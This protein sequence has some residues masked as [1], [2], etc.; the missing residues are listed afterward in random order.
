MRARPS[1]G[2]L[3]LCTSFWGCSDSVP[4]RDLSASLDT[5]V[6]LAR[7]G[8]KDIDTGP[9]DIG[10]YDT[11]PGAPCGY[12][13]TGQV[14]IVAPGIKICMPQVVCTSE[15]CP[16]PL[17]Q[18]VG[19]KCAFKGGYK[20]IETLPEAWATHYCARKAAAATA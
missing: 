13:Q 14:L 8:A 9:R 18:C 12:K 10:P 11:T 20:G 6:D 16:P 1:L 4:T 3:L 15:T 19:G 7:D 17:G 2:L 5:V